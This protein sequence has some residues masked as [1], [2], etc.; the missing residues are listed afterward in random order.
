M[1][2][3]VK[4]DSKALLRVVRSKIKKGNDGKNKMKIDKSTYQLH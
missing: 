4:F 1:W 3:A 2:Q